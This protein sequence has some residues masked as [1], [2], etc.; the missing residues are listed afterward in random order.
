MTLSLHF[1]E[2][3]NYI[4]NELILSKVALA[5]STSWVVIIFEFEMT[6]WISTIIPGCCICGRDAFNKFNHFIMI[7]ELDA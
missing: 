1:S 5:G 6:L 2:K 4:V 7:I 3:M